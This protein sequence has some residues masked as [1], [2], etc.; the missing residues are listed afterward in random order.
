MPSLSGSSAS[1]GRRCRARPSETAKAK[2]GDH[3]P[4]EDAHKN[5]KRPIKG[6]QPECDDQTDPLHQQRRHD[7]TSD[8]IKRPNAPAGPEHKSNDKRSEQQRAQ[9]NEH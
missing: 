1:L 3:H 5:P 7:Q 2:T 8:P 4:H 9:Q 6:R